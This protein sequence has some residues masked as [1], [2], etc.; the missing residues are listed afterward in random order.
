MRQVGLEIVDDPKWFFVRNSAPL[1]TVVVS[2]L[3]F[4]A[5]FVYVVDNVDLV[6]LN[7]EPFLEF[8]VVEDL[9]DDSAEESFVVGGIVI[10]DNGV[11]DHVKVGGELR[12]DCGWFVLEEE[13]LHV[14]PS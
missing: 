1:V 10:G 14:P 6:V 12:Q 11:G 8:V 4:P 3:D 7:D 13:P 2:K 5:F 9:V